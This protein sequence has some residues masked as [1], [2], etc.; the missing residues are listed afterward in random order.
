[1]WLKNLV[2]SSKS[3]AK[4]EKGKM[5]SFVSSFNFL[6]LCDLVSPVSPRWKKIGSRKRE[7]PEKPLNESMN[8]EQG[9]T[10]F[11]LR[12]TDATRCIS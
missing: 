3:Q 11:D 7:V 6:T 1:M 12:S 5:R 8:N 9:F 10:I 2:A 4:S